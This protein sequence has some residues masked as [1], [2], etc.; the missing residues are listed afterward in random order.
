M[1]QKKKLVAKCELGTV[2]YSHCLDSFV[3]KLRCTGCN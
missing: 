3:L 1:K 2:V